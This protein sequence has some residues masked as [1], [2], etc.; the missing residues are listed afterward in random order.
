MFLCSPPPTYLACSDS[1]KI[2]RH[3]GPA[4]VKTAD[5]SKVARDYEVHAV[6]DVSAAALKIV[7][8]KKRYRR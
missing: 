1:T 6:P 8:T 4:F 3:D 2:Y 5:S 7:R